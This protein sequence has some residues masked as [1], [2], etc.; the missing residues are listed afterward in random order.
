MPN[1]PNNTVVSRHVLSVLVEDLDGIGHV[2]AP[3]VFVGVVGFRQDRASE[4]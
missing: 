3:G 4:N 1:N 2:Y